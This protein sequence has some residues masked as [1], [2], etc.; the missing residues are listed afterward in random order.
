[1]L[2]SAI[3]AQKPTNR[4]TIKQ[5]NRKNIECV[6]FVLDLQRYHSQIPVSS[7]LRETTD[8]YFSAGTPSQSLY[9]RV[10]MP[11][12]FVT[13]CYTQDAYTNAAVMILTFVTISTRRSILIFILYMACN[14]RTFAQ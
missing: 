12:L 4:Q 2:T 10:Q 3:P 7:V 8:T 1:M 6:H 11:M 14:T 9:C 13:W 5:L